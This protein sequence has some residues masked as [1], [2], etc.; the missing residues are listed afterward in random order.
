MRAPKDSSHISHRSVHPPGA[1]K[2]LPR[3]DL[4]VIHYMPQQFNSIAPGPFHVGDDQR[5][6][7]FPQQIEGQTVVLHPLNGV[8]V[9]Q[10]ESI[11]QEKVHFVVDGEDAFFWRMNAHDSHPK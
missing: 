2:D 1:E 10:H 4:R 8:E 3:E 6:I 9:S 5:E 11:E 7:S